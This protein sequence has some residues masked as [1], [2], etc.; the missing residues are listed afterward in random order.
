MSACGL[1]KQCCTILTTRRSPLRLVSMEGSRGAC[2][3][4]CSWCSWLCQRPA[5]RNSSNRRH[6]RWDNYGWFVCYNPEQALYFD[7]CDRVCPGH[8]RLCAYIHDIYSVVD[9]QWVQ[10]KKSPIHWSSAAV[11]RRLLAH[12]FHSSTSHC[13][14]NCWAWLSCQCL[15]PIL[16]GIRQRWIRE[17]LLTRCV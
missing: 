6:S 9:L 1:Y 14:R 13:P 12:D 3:I 16:A 4:C 11:F 8:R 7:K 17:Q 2:S 15:F 5:V 10:K